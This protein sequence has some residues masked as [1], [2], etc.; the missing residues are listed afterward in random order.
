MTPY[1]GLNLVFSGF[2]SQYANKK[3]KVP[4]LERKIS[5]FVPTL[6]G[7]KG[8][9]SFYVNSRACVRVGSSVNDLFHTKLGF[10]QESVMSARLFD[11]SVGG[12]LR[13]VIAILLGRGLSF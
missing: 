1:M 3:Q 12:V 8:V 5:C 10:W 7:L 6:Y 11:I 4:A 13:E 2:H 9:Q